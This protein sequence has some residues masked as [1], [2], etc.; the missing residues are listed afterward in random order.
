LLIKEEY[1]YAYQYLIKDPVRFLE[2]VKNITPASDFTTRLTWR[3]LAPSYLPLDIPSLNSD[4]CFCYL[5]DTKQNRQAWIGHAACAL[6]HGIPEDIVREAW[7]Y[8]TQEQQ[9]AANKKA[10]E[11]IAHWE[12]NVYGKDI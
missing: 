7:S 6:A 9:D 3:Y 5:T 10:D 8:L 4:G 11:A 1:I 2:I 12:N